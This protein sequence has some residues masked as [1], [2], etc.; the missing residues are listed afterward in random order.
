MIG[1][2]ITVEAHI[3]VRRGDT[4]KVRDSETNRGAVQLGDVWYFIEWRGFGE[5]TR[6]SNWPEIR[7]GRADR[8][9]LSVTVLRT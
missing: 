6:Q 9:H 2:I 7:G 4:L 5:F 3:L 1:S 8:S